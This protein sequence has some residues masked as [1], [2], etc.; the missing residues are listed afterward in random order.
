M[1]VDKVSGAMDEA[2]RA[3]EVG[4]DAGAHAVKP[5]YM[6]AS[7]KVYRIFQ[8]TWLYYRARA[9]GLKDGYK[10]ART[11]RRLLRSLLRP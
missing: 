4:I 8:V 3:A 7:P 2:L 9:Q 5:N 6:L 1:V 11:Y 10:Q